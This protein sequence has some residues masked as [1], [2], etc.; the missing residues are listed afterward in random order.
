[1]LF[2]GTS[3]LPIRSGVTHALAAPLIV[4][5]ADDP[6][7]ALP[8]LTL[9]ITSLTLDQNGQVATGAAALGAWAR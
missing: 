3:V 1:M 8:E 7:G 5:G 4:R 2:G 9:M 6:L